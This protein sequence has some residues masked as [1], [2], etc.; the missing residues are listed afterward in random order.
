MTS[1]KRYFN[2]FKTFFWELFRNIPCRVLLSSV[3]KYAVFIECLKSSFE[4]VRIW[5]CAALANISIWILSTSTAFLFNKIDT[6]V[7]LVFSI[8]TGSFQSPFFCIR[9]LLV[10]RTNSRH[11]KTFYSVFHISLGSRFSACSR[12]TIRSTYLSLPPSYSSN[13]TS[14][15]S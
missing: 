13:I 9:L 2:R 14:A 12:S 10:S 15:L 5:R 4:C 3:E 7:A 6:F 1:E 8:E 11:T